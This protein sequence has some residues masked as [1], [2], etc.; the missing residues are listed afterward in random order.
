VVGVAAV[1]SGATA[2]G[3]AEGEEGTPV[4]GGRAAVS[5]GVG[6]AGVEPSKAATDATEEL[7]RGFGGSTGLSGELEKG[8]AVAGVAVAETE[9][10]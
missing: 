5:G 9:V 4:A 7:R 3:T 8:V 10:S 2:G 6:G 1:G